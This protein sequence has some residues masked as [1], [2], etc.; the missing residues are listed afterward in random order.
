MTDTS[1]TFENQ[2]Q[3]LNLFTIKKFG[4]V[5][6]GTKALIY[7]LWKNPES[8][9]SVT[10]E[11]IDN[12]LKNFDTLQFDW[13]LLPKHVFIDIFSRFAHEQLCYICGS[14]GVQFDPKIM[15]SSSFLSTKMK[16]TLLE[17]LWKSFE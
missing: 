8:L 9:G 3:N 11:T 1:D 17:T 4:K 10:K 5:S 12:E 15:R 7:Y 14:R 6:E 13:K 16:Q 2:N